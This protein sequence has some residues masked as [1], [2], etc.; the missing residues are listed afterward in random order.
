[1]KIDGFLIIPGG[2][3]TMKHLRMIIEHQRPVVMVDRKPKGYVGD[4]VAG[5]SFY[6]AVELVEHLV[7]RSH[8][9]I[10]FVNGPTTISTARDRLEGYKYALQKHGIPYKAEYVYEGSSF[11]E[12]MGELAVNH[13]LTLPEKPTAVFAANN[14]IAI[15][16]I[17]AL[18]R[19]NMDVPNDIALSCFE[20]I[21]VSDM[22]KPT[23]TAMIQPSYNFG[24]IATQLLLERIE[25]L[26]IETPRQIILRPEMILG[27][28]TEQYVFPSI[29]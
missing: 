6:G 22:I 19:R 23:V 4:F 11:N 5:D 3:F 7:A 24:T 15:G 14:F 8:R 2:D 20:K 28:S 17:R 25:G 21:E 29:S 18:R 27:E 1:L 9:K 26:Q 12:E 13:F 10:A 16:I